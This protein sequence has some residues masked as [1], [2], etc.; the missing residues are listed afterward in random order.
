MIEMKSRK[1][2]IMKTISPPAVINLPILGLSVLAVIVIL[3]TLRG[4]NN[5]FISNLKINLGVLMILGMM[6][7]AQGGIGRV[8]SMGQWVH[9]QAI[10]GYILGG[11]ILVLAG[12]IFFNIKLPF[13]TSPQGTFV[14]IA[15][16]IGLKILNSLAHAYLFTPK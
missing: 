7:C 4:S 10:L 5:P 15:A 3:M 12:S 2:S 16:L 9:P 13:T 8:A 6:I 14:F 1:E 11:L